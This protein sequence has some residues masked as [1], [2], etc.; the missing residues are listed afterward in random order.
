MA[1]YIAWHDVGRISD[2]KES[3]YEQKKLFN[4]CSLYNPSKTQQGT[5]N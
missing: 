3:I 2:M 4:L 5:Q 1:K